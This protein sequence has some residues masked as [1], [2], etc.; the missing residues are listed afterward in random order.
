MIDPATRPSQL[1]ELD[2]PMGTMGRKD[3]DTHIQP[4]QLFI[5]KLS[6]T[7]GYLIN[8]TWFSLYP[9]SQFIIYDNGSEFKLHF[10]TLCN[11]YAQANQCQ[12]STTEC[13]TQA[14]ASNNHGDDLHD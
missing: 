12:K 1:S 13:D 14:G 9:C 8:K 4:K 6:A 3:N 7:V 2:V 5:D 10:K 11:S